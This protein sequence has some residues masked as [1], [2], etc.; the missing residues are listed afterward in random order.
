MRIKQYLPMAVP[1]VGRLL[2]P[3]DKVAGKLPAVQQALREGVGADG[4]DP[5]GRAS[6]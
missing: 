4:S 6:S 3:V 1:R 5:W 2:H